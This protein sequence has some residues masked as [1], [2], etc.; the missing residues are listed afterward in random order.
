MPAT[1]SYK[2]SYPVALRSGGNPACTSPLQIMAQMDAAQAATMAQ[3][4]D[5]IKN[6]GLQQEVTGVIAHQGQPGIYITCTDGLARAL[7]RAPFVE[8]IVPEQPAA[9]PP[10]A[11]FKP[12]KR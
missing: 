5:F 10:R 2:I 1:K 11:T 3:L 4:M 7:A 9:P 6:G 8:S 12:F